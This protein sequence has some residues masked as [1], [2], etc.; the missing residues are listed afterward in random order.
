MLFDG[1]TVNRL[2]WI[3][4]S[5]GAFEAWQSIDGK[6]ER[7]DSGKLATKEKSPRLGIARRGDQVFFML[8]GQVGLEHTVRAMPRNFKVM[9][10]G[11]GTTE[12]HWD[13]VSVQTLKQQ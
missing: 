13:S 7:I 1:N 4:R 2:E 8:N 12:N 10:Y 3:L 11:F 5:D 6:M 9:L